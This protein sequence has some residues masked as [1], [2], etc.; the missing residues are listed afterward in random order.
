M[1]FLDK[2]LGSSNQ[3]VPPTTG[4]PAPGQPLPFDP[5][6][7]VPA[8][9]LEIQVGMQNLVTLDVNAVYGIRHL[10][11][12]RTPYGQGLVVAGQGR[13]LYLVV[14]PSG[15]AEFTPQ[16]GLLRV[17][18]P[19]LV[20][21]WSALQPTPGE[22]HAPSLRNV[23]WRVVPVATQQAPAQ[24]AG[25]QF[26]RPGA[27]MPTPQVPQ[28]QGFPEPGSPAQ[29]GLP[30]R[31]PGQQQ[32]PT[33]TGSTVAPPPNP[34]APKPEQAA[35]Q[36]NTVGAEPEL[37]AAANVGAASAAEAPSAEPLA[38]QQPLSKTI[39]LPSSPISQEGTSDDPVDADA[40]A[41][42]AALG[43]GSAALAQPGE[44]P[45]NPDEAAPAPAPDH[46]LAQAAS[47]GAGSAAVNQPSGAVETTP[48]PGDRPF[49][50]PDL[51]NA[52]A[53]GAGSA[54]TQPVQDR[55]V[56][57]EQA[58]WDAITAACEAAH[59]GQPAFH[60][61]VQVPHF[62]GGNDPLSLV[63]VYRETNG[64]P[65]WHYI[66]YGLSDIYLRNRSDDPRATS[67]RGYELTYRLADPAA[68]DQGA[69][70]PIWP[71][72]ELQFLARY[73]L[74]SGNDFVVGDHMR[75]ARPITN[76]APTG[77]T[78]LGFMA[79]PQL[80]AIRTPAGG[81]S[82][83]QVVGIAEDELDAMAGWSGSK[84]LELLTSRVPLGI[85]RLDRAS[86]LTDPQ[87]RAAHDEGLRRDGSNTGTIFAD[88]LHWQPTAP[89]Q[90]MV[91]IDPEGATA[92][93]T[94]LPLRLPFGRRF[95]LERNQN[96]QHMLLGFQSSPE[97]QIHVSQNQ[98][99]VNTTPQMLE[100]LG[101]S[102]QPHP[103]DY[104]LLSFPGLVWR[105]VPKQG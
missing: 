38:P 57:D 39:A 52:A 78:G 32:P 10:L 25:G 101:R 16:K 18:E 96:G 13:E 86:V 12:R 24:P 87:V 82:F 75:L 46:D 11:P 80:G 63:A 103:G 37:S 40:L 17:P 44:Q 9:T 34:W 56:N 66:G 35:A 90:T 50:E 88:T 95:A 97:P 59:P 23:V 92:L 62:M 51:T 93:R 72:T 77:L 41:A 74:G 42:A 30:P 21:L 76:A 67:G 91:T 60:F 2:F 64:E 33:R 49:P 19:V 5:T 6:E 55:P 69:Q 104:Q 100:E 102:L 47:L 99:V 45:G 70:P 31:N 48:N 28:P 53:V 27:L 89:G 20:E 29:T 84:F 105:V 54:N 71:V 61:R 85:T 81:V 68:A 43:A 83:V 79:D 1:G 3:N 94:L 26:G 58:G 14:D 8:E 98:L 73:V 22:F 15:I 4:A 7:R 65:H 36:A